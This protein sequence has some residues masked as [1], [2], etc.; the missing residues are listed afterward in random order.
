MQEQTEFKKEIKAL[1][2]AMLVYSLLPALLSFLF[3]MIL[4]SSGYNLFDTAIISTVLS[5][6][7]A[8]IF[9]LQHYTKKLQIKIP[10]QK[11]AIDFTWKIFFQY[12]IISLGVFWL[13]SF[14]FTYLTSFFTEYVVFDTPDFTPDG[15]FISNLFDVGYSVIL[16]PVFEE[17]IFRG[18][19]LSKLDKYGRTFSILTVSFVFALFHANLPQTV[20]TFFLSIMLCAMTL[21]CRSIYPA[22]ITHIIANAVG[23]A[24]MVANTDLLVIVLNGLTLIVMIAAIVLCVR[25]VRNNGVPKLDKEGPRVKEFFSNWASIILLIFSIL[26]IISMIILQ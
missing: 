2:I 5:M 13:S 16:A 14:I 18:M 19:M 22:I 15:T 3:S 7:T 11:P 4:F 21:R 20:P 9:T 26:G 6:V 24:S 25:Y 17:L 12:M 8:A 23:V 1:S 10:F